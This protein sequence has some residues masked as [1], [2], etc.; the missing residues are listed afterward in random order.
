VDRPVFVPS[1]PN[2][3]EQLSVQLQQPPPAA[4]A[5]RDWR[6]AY[7]RKLVQLDLAALLVAAAGA[8]GLNML[9]GDAK[10]GGLSYTLVALAVVLAWW[11]ALGLGR[12]YEARFLHQGT[13][14]FRRVANTSLRLAALLSFTAYGLQLPLSRSFAGTLLLG[15]TLLLLGVRQLARRQL[16]TARRQG[17]CMQ[18]VLALG[19][20]ATVREL[21]ASLGREPE[22]GLQIVGACVPGGRTSRQPMPGD[23]PVVGSLASVASAVK[24][25]R[26]D[27]VAVTA[28]QGL[29]ATTLRQ[30]SYE[31]EG[32]GVELLVSP[33]LTNVTGNRITIRPIAGVPLLH[34]DEPELE[35]ARRLVKATF[36][37]GLAA[38]AL[39]LLAPVL[40]VL[41]LAVRVTSPGPAFFRQERVGRDGTTFRLWKLRTMTADAE[42]RKQELMH[43]NE[44]DGVLFKIRQDPRIT[45]VGRRLRS[46]SLDELPQLVNVVLGHMSLVGPRPPLQ[47]EV[48]NYAGHAR[49]RLLVKPGITG[50]WQISG[51]SDLSWEE[52]VRLDLQYVES[53]S[54]GLDVLIIL[55]TVSSVL[56]SRGA[57]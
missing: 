10:V 33:S 13:E 44:H 53:W 39:L 31:L 56:T 38:L 29:T 55:K 4:A 27:V 40:T 16:R 43:L 47:S 11:A 48:A 32:T 34:V 14:E 50:L 51:R 3:S 20:H 57:Y 12:C 25:V 18:R 42:E 52:T 36:D 46:W 9:F 41:A 5:E 19:G 6:P 7:S 49:R 17:L 35:G 37:R 54:L 23:V 26:A 45:P 1:Y 28:S 24:A 15:G 2:V 30:L 8:L 21:A 22:S